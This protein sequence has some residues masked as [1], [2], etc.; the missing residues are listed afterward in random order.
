MLTKNNSSKYLFEFLS[1]FLAVVF[2][3]GLNNW[4]DNRH[5]L[6]AEEGILREIANGLRKDI[7]DLELNKSGHQQGLEACVYWQGLVGGKEA[8]TSKAIQSLG[9]L[10]RD[11]LSVQNRSGYESLK[12]R[13]LHLIR[14]ESLRLEIISLYEFEFHL[15][16]QLEENYAAMQFHRSYF[17]PINDLVSPSLQFGPSGAITGFTLP[18]ALDPPSKNRLWVY[19]SKIAAGRLNMM[20]LYTSA[21]DR[22]EELVSRIESQLQ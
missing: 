2:A 10:T 15:L 8:E 4:N 7:E 3:F 12:S 18:L 22:A 5:E 11:F 13:G 9:I 6:R 17:H 14:D 20:L 16:S 21:K 1:V 19:L